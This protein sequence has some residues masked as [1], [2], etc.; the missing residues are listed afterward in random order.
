VAITLHNVV[1]K[2]SLLLCG[3]AV[4]ST[5]GTDDLSQ[6]GH[7]S[8]A[9]PWLA[10]A[11]LLQA[12]SLAGL[13]PLSGFWGKLLLFR[14]GAESSAWAVLALAGAASFLTLASMLKIWIGAFWRQPDDVPVPAPGPRM[15]LRTAAIGLLVAATLALGLGAEAFLRAS[16][17]AADAAADRSGYVRLVREAAPGEPARA[18][19]PRGRGE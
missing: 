18:T 17:A 1:V 13:P 2:S 19:A 4:R 3:G 6:T 8:R 11:F 10:A 7:L 5:A 16:R 9:A 15:R 12:L 14:A